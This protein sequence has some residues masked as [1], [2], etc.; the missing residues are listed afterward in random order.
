[1]IYAV[2]GKKRF[3]PQLRIDPMSGYCHGP[4]WI[5]A[6]SVRR[7]GS[8]VFGGDNCVRRV[9]I[10]AQIQIYKEDLIRL[11]WTFENEIPA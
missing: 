7:D 6:F 3:R 10:A 11:G 5:T 8:V 4:Q 1:M 9:S 2:K